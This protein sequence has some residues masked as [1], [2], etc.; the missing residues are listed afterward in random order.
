MFGSTRWQTCRDFS[1]P[2]SG[3][4]FFN[5]KRTFSIVF[6]VLEDANYKCI[7]VD[8]DSYGK[9]SDSGIYA[10]SY[11][12]KALEMDKFNVPKERNLPRT[13]CP[14]LNVIVGDK[15]F[16]LKTHLLTRP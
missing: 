13:Q 16:P 8:V 4:Q 11:F 2:N 12:G 6:V 10:N 1:P 9:N 7:T 15:A 5:Y 3:S 14:T